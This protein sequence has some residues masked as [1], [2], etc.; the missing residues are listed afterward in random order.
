MAMAQ[1]DAR[2][3]LAEVTDIDLD[4]EAFKFMDWREGT[5]A[6][7]PARVFRISFTGELSFKTVDFVP[8]SAL[9]GVNIVDEG[10]D[11]M[12]WYTGPTVLQFLETV[13]I[14]H[15]TNLSEFRFPVQYVIRPDLHYRGFA[16]QIASGIVRVGDEITV[17]PSGKTTRV[18][19]IDTSNVYAGGK[20]EETIGAYLAANPWAKDHFVIATKGGI[21][22]GVPVGRVLAA[23]LDFRVPF[24]AFAGLMTASFFLVLAVVPQP[25]VVMMMASSPPS[26]MSRHHASTLRRA[27]SSAC[28]S[29]PM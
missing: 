7:V 25:D 6:G 20:S 21:V 4:R 18:T 2:K 26:S 14:K 5:V 3:L 27:C 24:L 9:F 15:D 29:R 10:S 11:K 1:S 28:S 23:G 17:L 8:I 22:L 19:H 16:G 12:P 13:E